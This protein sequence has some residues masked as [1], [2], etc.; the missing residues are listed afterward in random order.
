MANTK[1]S[2]TS[3]NKSTKNET[4]KVTKKVAKKPENKA[5]T[6]DVKNK[7]TS[8]KNKTKKQVKKQAKKRTWIWL[9]LSCVIIIA[10]FG[11]AFVGDYYRETPV[12]TYFQSEMSERDK[13]IKVAV[14]KLEEMNDDTAQNALKTT[15]KKYKNDYFYIIESKNGNVIEVRIGDYKITSI[16]GEKN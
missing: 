7:K 10:C 5:K 16:N 9:V 15:K 11:V 14:K 2:N 13:A 3:K 4:K 8:V 6:K 12:D 1:K